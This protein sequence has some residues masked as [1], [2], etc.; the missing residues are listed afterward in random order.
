MAKKGV[1]N[2]R[3]KENGGWMNRLFADTW[4]NDNESIL[5]ENFTV[6]GWK[7]VPLPWYQKLKEFNTDSGG[8]QWM[9]SYWDVI[10][11]LH[12]WT[13]YV[14]NLVSKVTK[15]LGSAVTSWLKY[16]VNVFQDK[17]IVCNNTETPKAFTY[18]TF[19]STNPVT[20]AFT[21]L[22]TWFTASCSISYNWRLFFAQYKV[23]ASWVVRPNVL[24]WS[25][26]ITT[27]ADLSP[28]FDF[29]ALTSS[30]EMVWDWTPITAFA[31]GQDNM[32][33][34]KANSV[35][36]VWEVNLAYDNAASPAV[37]G[38]SYP[39]NQV[40]NTWP[41]N[42]KTFTNVQQDLFYYD[43]V[44]VRRLSY[45]QNT[46]ALKDSSISENIFP[47]MNELPV[48]QT[49]ACSYFV[50]PYYK[51]HLH[52][53]TSSSND[54]GL[55]YNVINKAWSIQT[56]LEVDIW[57]SAYNKKQVAF[58]GWL[59]SWVVYEDNI[60]YNYDWFPVVRKWLSKVF[61]FWDRIDYKRIFQI[62][63][64]G[65]IDQEQDVEVDFYGDWNIIST[66]SIYYPILDIKDTTWAITAWVAT[67]WWDWLKT[68][69]LQDYKSRYETYFDARIYQLWITY[70]GTKYFELQSHHVQFK[71]VNPYDIHY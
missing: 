50:Y 47:L 65:R 1:T 59:Y 36:K 52:T 28:M 49:N 56:W 34:W 4:I 66:R 46:L 53:D 16:H 60:D 5:L 51:L 13:L 15:S 32:Y 10:V 69:P 29:S 38:V 70:E 33:I 54:Y 2:S 37:I 6:E 23:W 18:D 61:D 43:W 17:I 58:F 19:F 21:W 3:F 57:V 20:Q 25:K 7:I 22:S 11:A 40:T 9:G 68:N 42:Y 27:L 45:E 48:D 67:A 31:I 30:S 41:I 44:N 55:V 8:I 24:L 35:W 14:Y 64:N 12:N 63:L 39:I 26:W 62:E 71:F